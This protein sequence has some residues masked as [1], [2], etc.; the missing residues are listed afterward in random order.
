MSHA[1]RELAA[2]AERE[3]VDRGDRR[4]RHR[5]RAA[6]RLVAERAPRL[7][8]RPVEAAMYSMS[9]P[10]TNAFVARARED[11]AR[12]ASS[13]AE[14]AQPVAQLGQRLDVERVQRL[15]PVDRDDARRAS[16][17]ATP[18][19]SRRDG[20]AHEV[21]DLARRRAGLKTAATPSSRS[22]RRRPR[23]SCRRRRPRRPRHRSRAGARRSAARG[24]C[25]R[26]RGSRPRPR[27]RPPGSP[28][29]RSAP[30]SGGGPCR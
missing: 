18:T 25:A 7:R 4:L 11:D 14:L 21:D 15:L 6:R 16:S 9:A 24:S 28:S 3:A 5:P 1:E 8:A 2:A 30:A 17:R 12:A 10:A 19:L 22:C 26:R 20:A 27:R 13:V 29:R 23:G